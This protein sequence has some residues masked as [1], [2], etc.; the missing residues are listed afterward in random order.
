[1][2]V[3]VVVG[4]LR[5]RAGGCLAALLAEAGAGPLE[6]LLVDTAPDAPPVPGAGDAVVR[7]LEVPGGGTFGALRARAVAEARAPVVAFVE[8][9]VRVRPGWA[10]ALVAAHREAWAA[11]GAV[12]ENANPGVGRSDVNGLMSY[13]L[14]YPPATRGEVAVLPGNNSSFKRD[15]LLSYGPRLAGLL[16]NDNTLF[17][18][19]RRDGY[20]LLL[21][22]Q[23]VF[24]HL[25][26]TTLASAARGYFFYHRCYGPGRAREL[27]WGPCRRAAYVALAPLIPFYFAVRF[28]RLLARRRSPLLG[29]FLRGLPH[30]LAA[31]LAAACGQAVGLVRGPGDAEVRFTRYELSEPRPTVDGGRR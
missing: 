23:A 8:E 5:E 4:P 18:V 14:F 20:R 7:V 2:T 31:Q 24:G 3:V 27:G 15:V 30:V 17:A 13:G 21:E 11:V 29:T 28:G 25:N 1:M 26:E 16:A 10:S 22:P 12:A 19:L 9:H 6:V